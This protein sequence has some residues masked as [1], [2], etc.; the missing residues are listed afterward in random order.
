M[1]EVIPNWHPVFVHFTVALLSLSSLMFLVGALAPA[2][3]AWK[4]NCLTVARW[5][6]W[7]GASLTVL[8]VIAGWDA[9]NTVAHDGP[10][11]E[12][13]SDHRNWAIPTAL[14]YIFLAIVSFIT[15]KREST[16]VIFV[17]LMVMA[18]AALSVTGYKGGEAVYRYGLGVMSLP[19]ASGDGGHSSHDHGDSKGHNTVK[20]IPKGHEGHDHAH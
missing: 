7:I 12:A 17:L 13:M 16:S 6:L 11:H 1:F 3:A 10:S 8:T 20:P 18:L 15:R 9:Y 2:N 5:N 14:G 4:K 19:Q